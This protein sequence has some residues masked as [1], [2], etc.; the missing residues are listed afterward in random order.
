MTQTCDLADGIELHFLN[1]GIRIRPYEVWT[2]Q[3]RHKYSHARAKISRAAAELLEER[4]VFKEPMQVL[5][6]GIANHRYYLPDDGIT[7]G[8]EQAWVELLDPLKILEEETIEE[9]Y[10]SITLSNVVNDIF[11][12]RND[13]KRVIR[14]VEIISPDVAN[15]YSEDINGNLGRISPIRDSGFINWTVGNLVRIGAFFDQMEIEEGGF[16]FDGET[17]ADALLQIEEEFSVISWVD[18]NGTL[19]V[20]FPEARTSNVIAVYGDPEVDNVFISQYNVGTSRNSLVTL[21]GRSTPYNYFHDSADNAD[22]MEN[23]TYLVAEATLPGRDG[24][25]GEL[26]EPIRARSQQQMETIVRRKFEDAYIDHN[27]G[28]IEFSGM[29]SDD[30]ESLARLN[31]GDYI[32]VAPQIKNF[33]DKEFE[34]GRFVVNRVQHNINPRVGWSITAQVSRLV[35][36]EPRTQSW[37]YDPATDR[38]F[39]SIEEF[40]EES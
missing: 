33:C 16:F 39:D 21:R 25:Y 40:E 24:R 5:I 22:L 18:V 28:N 7:Y 34:G 26:D 23:A 17:L 8:E 38:T 6:G 20:G 12:L 19:V 31:V 13:P 1:S 36:E 32:G 2:R 11:D 3:Q 30:Q 29:S 35:P 15:E 9:S 27:S 37:V 14:R 4:R 10:N